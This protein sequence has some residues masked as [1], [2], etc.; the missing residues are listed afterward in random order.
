MVLLVG[1]FNPL[2]KI[3]SSV[4]TII[5]N[6]W[7]NEIHVPNHQAVLPWYQFHCDNG[8]TGRFHACP[9]LENP[10]W[11]CFMPIWRFLEIGLPPVIIQILD[12]DLPWNSHE[13][14][15]PAI[16][17]GYPHDYGTPIWFNL[18]LSGAHLINGDKA[19]LFSLRNKK[20][21]V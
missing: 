13:I 16:F 2:W 9:D 10:T 11:W 17:W 7:K 1:G 6:I 4:G 19:N 12:W 21:F 14:N 3:C 5:P 8:T 20:Q 18:I 15:H